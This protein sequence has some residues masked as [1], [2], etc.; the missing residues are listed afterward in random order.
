MEIQGGNAADSA[1][2]VLLPNLLTNQRVCV[3]LLICKDTASFN[4]AKRQKLCEN[5]CDSILNLM[6]IPSK[7]K[8]K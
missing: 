6:T 3:I 4:L 7:K 8:V 1:R 2:F 5:P